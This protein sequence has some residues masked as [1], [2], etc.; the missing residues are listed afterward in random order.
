MNNKSCHLQSLS[1]RNNNIATNLDKGL[2][3][4][5]LQVITFVYYRDD[6]NHLKAKTTYIIYF[7]LRYQF[8]DHFFWAQYESPSI[9]SIHRCRHDHTDRGM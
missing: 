6:E 7:D 4:F 9:V 2:R 5:T 3:N 1:C 8:Q